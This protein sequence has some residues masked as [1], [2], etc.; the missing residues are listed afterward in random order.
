[1]VRSAEAVGVLRRNSVREYGNPAGRPIVFA[2]GFGCSQEM[3]RRVVPHFEAD[4][5]VIV[6]DHVGAGDSDLSAYD[7]SKYDSLHGYAD[8]VLEILD[9]LDVD[10]VVFVGHSVSAMIG[11]LAANRSPGRF[12]QLVLVGPSA[13]YIDDGAYVG[14]F[15]R[16]DID[17]LLDALDANYLGWSQAVAPMIAGDPAHPE[18]GA[19][20]TES[21]CRTDPAIAAHFARVT[22]LS[23]NRAD[24]EDVTVPTVVMQCS[25][26]SIA[27]REVGW[28]VH[29]HIRDSAFV[30]LSAS[31]HC[32]NLSGPDELADAITARL[33]GPTPR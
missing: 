17:G 29:E 6:F 13:R 1:M 16:P 28:F 33:M 14:G 5:R 10:D 25:E 20:L 30:Q 2:H 26:D 11:V 31:G 27:P 9:A 23:D 8:D 32:P 4:F 24:L 18:V 12:G 22:F 7:R 3:W 19:E 15:T 21:F